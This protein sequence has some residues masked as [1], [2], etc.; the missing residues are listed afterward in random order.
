MFQINIRKISLFDLL[1]EIGLFDFQL[2]NGEKF[3]RKF[4]AGTKW[5]RYLT[6]FSAFNSFFYLNFEIYRLCSKR[7][8]INK[9]GID[10]VWLIA[11]FSAFIFSTIAVI[12]GCRIAA[13]GSEFLHFAEH[14]KG[15]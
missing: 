4:H 1:L 5:R 9:V 12:D 15:G 6:V 10:F 7:P 2:F 14:F 13:F 3:S 11:N 8:S